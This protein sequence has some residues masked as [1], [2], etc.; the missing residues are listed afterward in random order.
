LKKNGKRK[1]L[2]YLIKQQHIQ[3]FY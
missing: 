3:Q 2:T 1:H